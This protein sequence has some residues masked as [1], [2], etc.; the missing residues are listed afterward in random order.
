M[1]KVVA[2][3]VEESAEHREGRVLEGPAHGG[4]GFTFPQTIWGAGNLR[5]G[6]AGA[7]LR[8]DLVSRLLA[9]TRRTVF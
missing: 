2:S 8:G 6:V 5:K 4:P 7:G 1:G 9:G 3:G